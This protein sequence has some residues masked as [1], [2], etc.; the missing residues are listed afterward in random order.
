[1]KVTGIVMAGT[2]IMFGVWAVAALL[3]WTQ[4]GE[5]AGH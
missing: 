1:M 2:G 3:G 4:A 5:L